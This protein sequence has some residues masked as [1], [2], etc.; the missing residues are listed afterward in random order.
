[1]RVRACTILSIGAILI[2]APAWAAGRYDPDYPICME[3]ISSEGTRLDCEY[4]SME[5]CKQGVLGGSS[6]TCFNNPSYV[7][8]P[9]AAAPAQTEPELPAKPKKNMGRYDPDYAVCMEVYDQSGSRI[10]CFFTS[11]EQCKLGAT[12]TAGSCFNNPYYVAPAPEVA[13][14]PQ[15]EPPPVKRAK[16]AKPAK[17]AK[18]PQPP[19]SP[20]PAP[21][22]QR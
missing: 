10:E 4:T 17:S 7:P 9:A 13:T 3:S 19:P 16:S 1:M 5:Q 18:S 2:A 6:G 22:P 8:R 15:T 20:Q 21:S 12:A 14:A 11:M